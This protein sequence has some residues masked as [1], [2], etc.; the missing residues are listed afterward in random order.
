[1]F[2]LSAGTG[3]RKAEVALPNG[4]EMDDRRLRR[5]SLLWEIDGTI[6]VS[7]SPSKLRSLVSGR[8]K[9]IFRPPRSKA[10]KPGV[11]WGA[12]PIWQLFD[13]T[14]AA[15]AAW[16]LQQLELAFPQAGAAREST[17]LLLFSNAAFKPLL[18]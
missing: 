9:A 12:H 8:D 7:P 1:M 10:D 15:N 18:H 16:R 4:E 5:A 14:D 11:I 2:A 17:P 13:D 3:F 6:H